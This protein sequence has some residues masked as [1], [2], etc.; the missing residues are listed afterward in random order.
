M[1]R[2]R[3]RRAAVVLYEDSMAP[4]ARNFGRHA[5]AKACVADDIGREVDDL[6]WHAIPLKGNGNVLKNLNNYLAD[7]PPVVAVYDADKVRSA[8]GL[9]GNAPIADVDRTIRQQYANGE[10]QRL[11]L[12]FLVQNLETLLQAAEGCGYPNSL[13]VHEAVL[14]KDRIARDRV[15]HGVAAGPRNVRD[16]I[17]RDVPA[18][19]A[20]VRH[21]TELCRAKLGV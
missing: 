16:C 15:C 19:D 18:F 11:T 4:E 10:I 1:Q 6:L 7:E 13:V 2:D 21:L 3:Q 20:L 14:H 5:L 17:R 9:P 8:V 12:V